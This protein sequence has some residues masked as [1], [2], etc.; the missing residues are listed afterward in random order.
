MDIQHM[1]AW[2][3][4]TRTQ[5]EG[6]ILILDPS[7]TAKDGLLSLTGQNTCLLPASL[8]D[9]TPWNDIS[10]YCSRSS[11]SRRNCRAVKKT[12]AHDCVSVKPLLHLDT[13]IWLHSP[14]HGGW[15]KYNPGG[16]LE[17]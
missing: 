13:P 3:V 15:Y 11:P 2:D 1:V 6:R 12:A 4:L 16:H 7:P 14:G 10:A 8:L 5:C 9:T 17:L